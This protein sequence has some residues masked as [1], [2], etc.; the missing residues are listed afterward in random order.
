MINK[1]LKLIDE[2]ILEFDWNLE[3]EKKE[4]VLMF[5]KEKILWEGGI[6]MLTGSAGKG[7]SNIVL[8]AIASAI[9][10]EC[11]SLGFNFA[12]NKKI[13]YY[14]TENEKNTF[15]RNVRNTLQKRAGVTEGE[16][17]ENVVFRCLGGV[18]KVEKKKEIVF[19]SIDNEE[20]DIYVID[21]ITD[22]IK[23]V[24]DTN[25]VID[26]TTKLC[27]SLF[28]K[29]KSVFLT[30]HGNPLGEAKEK[31]RGVLGSELL[32]KASCSLLLKIDEDDR[33]CVTT[34]FLLGKNRLGDD[35]LEQY[36]TKDEELNMFV[37]C[38]EPTPFCKSKNL[39][40]DKQR[41]EKI[42]VLIGNEKIKAKDLINIL[43]AEFK[44]SERSLFLLLNRAV[45]EN[46]ISKDKNGYY[47]TT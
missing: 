26:F 20:F 7:K 2:S 28:N 27:S 16:K 18:D 47:Y 41:I 39:E 9:N 34:D 45:S 30:I 35:K 37:S 40:K 4:A 14:D 25:E 38:Q 31:A 23:N 22:L 36:F 43:K 6:C 3:V 13:L 24:N 33:R 19:A 29:R 42:A 1:A 32:R 5:C 10:P 21:T 46:I 8:A 15:I 44:L 17:I 11:D 12:L